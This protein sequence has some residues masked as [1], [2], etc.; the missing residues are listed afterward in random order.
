MVFGW[1]GSDESAAQAL[2]VSFLK[3]PND[4]KADALVRLLFIQLDNLFLRPSWW[5][6]LSASNQT[7]LNEMT[8]SGTMTRAP[9]GNQLSDDKRSFLVA[10]VLENVG[11]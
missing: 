5:E 7:A 2:M 9:S 11:R 6:S 1:I 8:K 3:V 10:N 4:R